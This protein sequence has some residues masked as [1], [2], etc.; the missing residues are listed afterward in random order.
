M[1]E[2][3]LLLTILLV[4][5]IF[6]NV[7]AANDDGPLWLSMSATNTNCADDPNGSAT[8]EPKGGTAPFTYR[9]Q[10]GETTATINNL[11]AGG[12]SVTVVDASGIEDNSFIS[13]QATNKLVLNFNERIISCAKGTDGKLV[14]VPQG[15]TAPFT[16]LWS[17]GSNQ[18][19]LENL[20]QGV[21]KVTVTDATGCRGEAETFLKDPEPLRIKANYAHISCGEE[22]DGFM[23]VI[24]SGGA[25]DYTFFWALDSLGGTHREGLKPG[26]YS[27]TV[28][29]G[30]GCTTFICPEIMPSQPPVLSTTIVPETCPGEGDG[31]G[32][33][34]ANGDSPPYRFDW[35][36]GESELSF[37]LNLSPGT[38]PVTV[39]NFRNCT[40]VIDVVIGQAG[41]GFGFVVET[42]GF[43]CGD[44]PNGQATV[45][46][47]G[48]VGPFKY[49]WVR[50]SD[51]A[52]ISEAESVANF[53]PGEY[54]VLVSD[55]NGCFGK[56]DVL[57]SAKELPTITAT[58]INSQVCFG[59]S[60]GSASVSAT[61]GEGSYSFEWFNGTTGQTIENLPAGNHGVT[62]TDGNGCSA[63]TTVSI[64]ESPEMVI[65]EQV[66]DLRCHNTP[67]GEIAVMVTGGSGIY[68][69]A[70]SNNATA[71]SITN[72]LAGTY[73]VT[74]TDSDNCQAVK[75]ITVNEPPAIVLETSSTNATDLN[76]SDGS[77][78]VN[79]T[80]GTM[81]YTYAWS[82]GGTTTTI[83]NIP[84]GTYTVMVT[85]GNGCTET[86]TVVVSATFT[87]VA[88]IAEVNNSEVCFGEST[89]SA[90]VSASGGQGEYGFEW[91]NGETGQ[92]IENLPAG[93]HNVTVS[94]EIGAEVIL[95]VSITESPEIIITEQ[96]ENLLCHNVPE[97]SVSV[98]VT[99]G[100]GTY[101]YS[102]SNGATTSSIDNL[103]AGT[104]VVTITD[105]NGCQVS[106]EIT[107]SEPPAIVLTAT[108]TSASDLNT[109]DGSASVTVSGGTVPYTYLWSNGETTATI[110]NIPNG[111]YT[112]TV[113]DGNGCSE[114][115][116]VIVDATCTL[117]AAITDARPTSCLGND[118]SITLTLSGA[119][120]ELDIKW[121][122]GGTG[123][124]QTGLTPGFYG[125][126]V[127]DGTECEFIS[128]TF[129]ADGCNCTQPVL[130]KALVFEADC[131]VSNGS[132]KI[133]MAGDDNDFNYQWSDAAITGTGA[134]GLPSGTYQVT[135]TAKDN[136][137]CS[138]EETINIGNTNIGPV[139]LL[140]SNPEICN[141]TKGT[142][143]LVPGNLTF[144]WSDGGT[145]GF[146]NDLSAGE[147]LVTVT[148]PFLEGCQ[149]YINVNIGL[150]SGLSLTP[151]INRRPDC[152]LSNGSVTINVAGG[153]GN[154]SY[155]W[156]AATHNHLPSGTY[157]IMVTDNVSGCTESVLFTLLENVGGVTVTLD[158]ISNV[159]CAGRADGKIDYRLIETSDFV[160]PATVVITD[161]KGKE[162][163]GTALPVGNYCL[164]VK[165][166]N[167]CSAGEACFEI[168]EPD[169][170]LVNVT[171]IPKTCSVN[172]TILLTASGGNG[173]YTY[174][175]ADQ[176]GAI[177][178]RDRRNIEN[179]TYSVTVT[180]EGGCSIAVDDVMIEGEC[181][182]CALDVSA[183]I[184]AIPECGL[185]IGAATIE[186]GNSFGNVTYS[187]GADSVRTDL[188]SGDYTV[189]ITDDFRGCDTTVSFTI[190]EL[191][192][193]ME[194]TIAELIVCQDETGMLEY[195]LN[196]FRCFKQPISAIITDEA[197]TIY[198][199]N[200]LAA[201]GNYIFVAMDGDG[202]EVNRQFFSVEG[203]DSILVTGTVVDEGCTTLGA[204]DLALPRPDS[205]YTIQWADLTEDNQTI[206]R[207]DLR[208]GTYTVTITDHAAGSCSITQ[209]YT[210][211]K[212]A[213]IAA[214]LVSEILT[215]DIAPVEVTLEGEGIVSYEWSPATLV[216]SGQG[217]ANPVLITDGAEST[218][219][220]VATNAFGCSVERAV[221]IKSVPTDLAGSIVSSPQCDG[222]T[223]DFSNE[224]I[225]SEFYF[226]DFGDGNTSDAV[227][228]SHTYAEAGDYDVQLRLKP[229]V[230]CA[231]ERGIL[232]SKTLNLVVAAETTADFEI[233]YDACQDEGLISFRDRS[234]VNPG[235]ITNWNW[236]FGNGMTSTEQNPA[237]TLSEDANLTVSLTIQT[238]N[239]CDDGTTSTQSFKV[240]N[241][242]SVS[243]A[244]Q[245][246][247]G[248]PTALNPNAMDG[249][250]TYEW[251]PAELLNDPFSANPIA[252]TNKPAEFTVKITQG[253][254]VRT[255]VVTADVP[256]EQEF[257]FSED[258]EV[259]DE[260]ER[261]I[262]VDGPE[263]ST[264][265]WTDL[266]TGEVISTE[267]EILVKPSI[268]QVKLTDEN[269][270]PVTA[271]IAIENFAIEAAIIDNTDP[272]EGGTGVL[273]IINEGF[274]DITEFSWTDAE[275]IISAE[276]DQKE[277]EVEPSMT[278][279]YTVN[280]K[281]AF[282][283]ELTLTET[284]AVSNLEE[285]VIIPDRDTIFKG[286]FTPINITPGG[287]YT[288]SWEASPTLSS[289]SGFDQ[290]A[291]P[292]ETT[293]Y[294]VTIIDDATGCS[295]TQEV[296]VFVR[297][298]VCGEPNIFFP[299]AF[300]PNGDGNNDVLFVRG[301]ALDEV[302]FQIFNRWGELVFES[303]SQDI[304]WD[305]TFK[306]EVVETDVFGYYLKVTCLNG[307]VFEKQ[308]NV[309]VIN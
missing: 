293:T 298:V 291:T 33:I 274:E 39:T 276:L 124:S 17:N 307:D 290:V 60:T 25:G 11:V 216:V 83:N 137:A 178:P 62:V 87:L 162:Y 147:Y 280:L 129:I 218:I 31:R 289:M 163:N 254:C 71:A 57:F 288:V 268:Y 132:L 192:I 250:A 50:I 169:F 49:Q 231:E 185:P 233:D 219:T 75:E 273:E 260:E 23:D 249:E 144:D 76:T 302:F 116:T 263:N 257:L 209:T 241:L 78:S 36:N 179:G 193:P 208:E 140:Q 240:F 210:V 86:T 184:D 106:K 13:V 10:N 154:Y 224:N 136:S 262:F 98:S 266:N 299:N 127:T 74:V 252:T 146:R 211:R 303:N 113:T 294:T 114:T 270:C 77:A 186:V 35:P 9:W 225:S 200:A 47:T 226:W 221:T 215:C 188:L 292:E 164:I 72:L 73:F 232:D 272:C 159:S 95:T 19:A 264:I 181:F 16:Y 133:T 277:I 160:G 243:S 122:N 115:I 5:G 282:G 80:G 20:G 281:N 287:D 121:S 52:T 94:D 90:T 108:S 82:N 149:D 58:T 69:Y 150:E 53:T 109:A 245:I 309:T 234:M 285:M 195:D 26:E 275:G 202:V 148:N 104:Y 258:E 267:A 183:T 286:E 190:P 93:N 63:A 203:Y 91:F 46:I 157:D 51:N 308:G 217:T 152:G 42:T 102:W 204:I 139:L 167:G 261:L 213:D 37:A 151:E 21:Y 4:L 177:N 180:D 158:T 110:N 125:V 7:L 143:L 45:V 305:G 44:A 153:S 134:T 38:Y 301:N 131:G 12:Y 296:T 238:D 103:A 2:R 187:W 34:S 175:W 22:A 227:N 237:I 271:E 295:I 41:G 84:N 118:G 236:D 135:I 92:T 55:A 199:E 171:V 283:C 174:N 256:K 89:A 170:L 304:G 65:S 166:G 306:G 141:G 67:E 206:D 247:P 269:N 105:S 259:C 99:G 191:E 168:T 253:E 43:T 155:S 70:W 297:D 182:I 64:T 205:N 145:G 189:T 246:C 66:K 3:N 197:G 278:T 119:K 88:V 214:N 30:N 15:G 59:E 223:I 128:S 18:S 173:S 265:E 97:G 161:G 284:V 79:A 32:Y 176:D 239:G 123:S 196:N 230:P 130:E 228:P 56:Q 40:N 244:L 242:P 96:V 8:V 14:A 212:Q 300:T 54:E 142:A 198:D 81:P 194:A 279:D 117:V 48:G 1:N 24:A 222:L 248:I 126:T 27:V 61:G 107:I 156:G 112:V 28:T 207:N 85:D 172:N 220:V 165:D 120:N 251:S 229:T 29:D 101:T 111:T 201:F 235:V 100:S 138:I 255:S 68:T 6:S